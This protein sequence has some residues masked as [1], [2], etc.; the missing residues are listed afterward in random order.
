M[1]DINK[2]IAGQVT[3][4]AIAGQVSADALTKAETDVVFINHLGHFLQIAGWLLGGNPITTV[5]FLQN[6]TTEYRTRWGTF[7]EA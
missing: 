1:A 6:L 2:A 5:Y 4:S 7:G 3:T